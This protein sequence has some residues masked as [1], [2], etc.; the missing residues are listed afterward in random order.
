VRGISGF[1][2]IVYGGAALALGAVDLAFGE[3][4]G[5][6]QAVPDI[7]PGRP[8]LPYLVGALLVLAG[9]ALQLRKSASAAALVLVAAYLLFTS[10]WLIRVFAMPTELGTWLGVC[11]Q[12]A[13]AIGGLSCWLLLRP[14]SP[15]SARL[16]MAL[17]IGFGVCAV[18]FG[19]AHFVYSK[20]T[21]DFVPAWIPP[22]QLF[23]A[24]ATGI[25]H[26]LGG[27]ALIANVRALLAA[28]L[29]TAM[30]IGF[31]LLVW[32]PALFRTPGEL[33]AWGGNAV[34]L[35][36]VAAA[37]VMADSIARFGNSRRP[38]SQA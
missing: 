23:W 15:S 29:L 5:P 3:F 20:E 38:P 16:A 12:L 26:A 33:F 6:W 32:L 24:Y 19:A 9:G 31:G 34:N 36:L 35:T 14:N 27:M 37:W 21:A 18:V 13:V 28:R 1:G 4:A 17:R 22:G 8:L 25:A 10:G 7:I 11:E 30:F 2:L